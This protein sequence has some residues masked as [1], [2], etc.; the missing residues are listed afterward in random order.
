MRT[1]TEGYKGDC[2]CLC[3]HQMPV[4]KHPWNKND[5]A[6]GSISEKMGYVCL[7]NADPRDEHTAMFSDRDHGACELFYHKD[8]RKQKEIVNDKNN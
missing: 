1:C 2:C 7:A 5:W 8:L 6:K 3:I 4:V